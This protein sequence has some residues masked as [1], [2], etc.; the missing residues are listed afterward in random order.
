MMAD[1]ISKEEALSI[2]KKM[3]DDDWNMCT[4]TTW[5]MGYESAADLIEDIPSADVQPVRHGRWIA[6][7]DDYPEDYEC[8]R[9]GYISEATFGPGGISG[10]MHN[11][12]PNC[13]A[14]MRGDEE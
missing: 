6:L 10:N 4:G 14:D 13:G 5:A 9:C 11:Y 8:D 3:A 2:L 7:D 1:Y 12:C